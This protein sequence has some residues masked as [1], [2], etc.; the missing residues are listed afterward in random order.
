VIRR[1]DEL[2]E[3]FE[4][5][6]LPAVAVEHSSLGLIGATTTGALLLG[7]PRDSRD[8]T[9]TLRV[10]PDDRDSL[11]TAIRE[12][13][14]TTHAVRFSGDQKS[15]RSIALEIRSFDSFAF[16][17]LHESK[18]EATSERA[19]L[20]A[21]L[22]AL[23]FDVWERD[24][25]G[26][27]IRQNPQA[28]RNWGAQL[29]RGIDDMGLSPEVTA[30]WKAMND[31]AL[32]GEIVSVPLDYEVAGRRV[33]YVNLIAPV[34]EGGEIRG[35]VGVNI[36]ITATRF[37]EAE[38][39]RAQAQ[40]VQ[41]ERLAALGELA[42]VVA[43]EV[44]NPLGAI[45]NSLSS[46][47]RTLTLTG[48]SAVL[49]AIIEEE[50]ARLNRTVA[51][52]LNY[53]RPLEPERRAEDLLDLT[54][55]CLRQGMRTAR[56]GSEPIES[57]VLAIDDIDPFPTDPV[58]LRIALSNLVT[59]AVQA[60]PDGGHLKI[61]IEKTKHRGDDA[62][63]ITVIDTGKGIPQDVLERVFEPFFTT[64]ASGTGL[65]L[66]VVRRIVEAHEGLVTAKSDS[67]NG[68]AFTLLLP[69]RPL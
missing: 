21:L 59:N 36:D 47:R 26:T 10:H 3:T 67:R 31:R 41:R 33:N 68:T 56:A 28:L 7:V 35:V 53:V 57:E 39:A 15:Y 64:R 65:G 69:R 46:L 55:D 12:K 48:D 66:A 42:A 40:L 44:R 17:V 37:A 52:L 60:M 45:F 43:H 16:V 14:P 25:K 18:N 22:E 27:L 9:W 29:G 38:L 49:F 61:T 11:R 19:E 54:R 63:A 58:L 34:R 13:K 30:R 32:A 5:L 4:A 8:E 50:S 2:L 6:A 51:D 24:A 20:E 23:P 62:V 1:A